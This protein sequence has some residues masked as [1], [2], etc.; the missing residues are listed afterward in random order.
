MW[1]QVLDK[2]NDKRNW[3]ETSAT[4]LITY[5]AAKLYNNGII[6]DEYKDMITAGYEGALSKAEISG[7]TLSV[8]NVC[9][10]TGVGREEY[11]LYRPT[12]A[13]DLHGAGAFIMMCTE[14]H[15]FLEKI[16]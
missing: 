2:V 3:L 7:N 10:G 9:V 1:Y 5:A 4:S 13:N 8:T 6:G 12:V 15:K 16:G 14:V 11:Y